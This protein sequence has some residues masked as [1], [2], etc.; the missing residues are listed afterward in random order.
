MQE[1]GGPITHD[2]NSPEIYGTVFSLAPGKTDVNI[3]WAGSDDGLLNVTRDGG[4]AWTNVTP[5]E[6]PDFGR[7]S[8]IDSS[9]FDPAVAY[10]AVKR[11]LLD[12]HA[13]YIF[14]TRDFGRTWTKIVAGIGAADFVHTVREDPTRKGLLYAGT[15]H[16]VYVSFDD[17]DHWQ[18]VRLNMPDSPAADLWVEANDLVVTLHGRGFW[19]LDDIAPLRQFG[20]TPTT[21]DAQL[22]KPADAIRSVAPVM[23]DYWLKKPA[24]NLTLEILDPKG[25][26]VRTYKGVAPKAT[27]A[28]QPKAA[29]EPPEE[30]APRK[31]RP[32]SMMAGLNRFAWDLATEPVQSFPGMVLWGASESGPMVLAGTYQVRLT[33]DGAA[34]AQPVTVRR[35]PLRTVSDSDLQ[36]QY[37]LESQIRDKVNEANSAVIQIRRIKKDVAD[38]L[39]AKNDADLRAVA[40]R[41][42]RQLTEVEED[43]YQV[44]NQSN[45]DPLNFPIKIN[46]RLASL[47]RAVETGDGRPTGNAVPIFND[48]KLELKMQ[49]DRLQQVLTTDLPRFNQLAQK[50]GLQPVADKQ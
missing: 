42:T 46:N 45:Q 12:D 22:F 3:L 4:K 2:M 7:V 30:D 44:R 47:L 41:L 25:T 10:V 40:N 29:D 37:D 39:A 16:G 38:R 20:T 13:P 26:V 34:Q 11:P 19:I 17:G 21:S 50:L 6:M 1:S 28:D 15:E 27:A 23:I 24:Q 35:N 49:T 36:A 48:I 31:Q 8:Q 18:S 43:V 32:P 9:M 5:K 33:V 14:R